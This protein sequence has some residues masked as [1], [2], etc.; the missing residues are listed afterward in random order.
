VAH[1]GARGW[2]TTHGTKEIKQGK[3]K[4]KVCK[5][6]S[7]ITC[8]D[9]V[10]T[11]KTKW[12]DF[13]GDK[14]VPLPQHVFVDASGKELSRKAGS[15]TGPDFVKLINEAVAKVEGAKVPKGDYDGARSAIR[16]GEAL[17]RKDEIKK[18][19]AAFTKVT[20]ST[21]PSLAKLGDD[22][23]KGL[24]VSGD[25]RVEAAIQQM[26]TN[27]DEAAK[28]LKKVADEYKPLECA[29]KAADILKAMAEKKE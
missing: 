13:F 11:G 28:V 10:E 17:V 29:T 8:D 21:H 3:D 26:G 1:L 2:N 19:I 6:Y 15:V 7:T 23:L 16:D 12:N 20:K 25:A 18:A 22:Q 24:Q 14:T 27:V 5:I 4:Y 9:H